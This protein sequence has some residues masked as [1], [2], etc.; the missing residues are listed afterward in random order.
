MLFNFDFLKINKK[1]NKLI[2]AGFIFFFI[3]VYFLVSAPFRSVDTNIHISQ[4]QSFRSVA[5]ELKDKKVIRNKFIL[6]IFCFVFKKNGS[7]SEGDYLFYRNTPIY[8]VAWQITKGSHNTEM[9]KITL[10]EGITN[11]QIAELLKSK[12][13][14]F[15]ENKFLE[16]A[17]DKQGYLFPDTYFLYPMTTEEEVIK[18]MSDNFN[19]KI[20]DINLNNKN[21]KDIIIMA[22]LLEGEAS[23]NEDV[24]IISGILWKRLE[25]GMRLQ[26]DASPE[27]YD[28][29]GLPEKPI[30]N[31]GLDFIK[32][33]INPID[34]EY[35]FYLHDDEGNV[36]FSKSFEEHKLNIKKYLKIN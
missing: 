11:E 21:L 36:H 19:N 24:F 1:I 5:S 3:I 14:D 26:I 8:K 35:L 18:E 29:L 10:R 31:P 28:D 2:V 16:L 13:T 30:N 9:I 34:S 23:G 12:L 17:T 33:A 20:Q 6:E 15:D 32:A 25:I 22:S 7:I 27:T 4:G